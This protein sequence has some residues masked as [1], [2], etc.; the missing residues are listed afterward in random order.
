MRLYYSHINFSRIVT[1]CIPSLFSSLNFFSSAC[2]TF[3]SPS[4][5]SYLP[6]TSCRHFFPVTH[7]AV[8]FISRS[9]I[10]S[11]LNAILSVMR[12]DVII[13]S[14]DH[15]LGKTHTSESLS[16]MLSS[17]TVFVMSFGLTLFF[18]MLQIYNINVINN[19]IIDS[20]MQD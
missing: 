20:K 1:R 6:V 16:S 7:C 15:S 19:Y 14:I 10:S 13:V 5:N 12:L 18:A 11:A 9:S 3:I 8:S 4:L 17:I 2:I